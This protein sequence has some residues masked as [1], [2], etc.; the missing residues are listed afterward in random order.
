MNKLIVKGDKGKDNIVLTTKQLADYYGISPRRLQQNFN[1]NSENFVEGKHYFKL[2]GDALSEFKKSLPSL[3]EFGISQFASKLYVWTEAGALY[4]CKILDTKEAWKQFDDILK[5]YF[6]AK[7]IAKQKKKEVE[8]TTV[9]QIQSAF[10]EEI[11][12]AD[13]VTRMLDIGN[14]A[15]IKMLIRIYKNYGKEYPKELPSAAFENNR[16]IDSAK[17]LLKKYGV[18]NFGIIK[19]F[20]A[21]E[22]L[23]MIERIEIDLKNGKIKKGKKLVGKGLHYG[24]NLISPYNYL[25]PWTYFYEDS[26]EELLELVREQIITGNAKISEAEQRILDAV[27]ILAM[28][29]SP[30]EIEVREI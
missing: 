11:A 17:R 23:G 1:N 13:T 24:Q 19:F 21:L 27:D 15:K 5:V 8:P 9:L 28:Q 7:K 3:E 4:H 12:V 30:E 26:F 10:A 22:K 25:E 2:E 14:A 6:A 20:D 16:T 29:K 18:N